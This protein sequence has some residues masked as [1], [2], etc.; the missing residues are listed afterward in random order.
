MRKLLSI[1]LNSLVLAQ[2]IVHNVNLYWNSNPDVS[3]YVYY[4]STIVVPPV[5]TKEWQTLFI[6]PGMQPS[7]GRTFKPIGNGV[8]QPVLTWGQSCA[9]DPTNARIDKEKK[10]WISAQYVNTDSSAQDPERKGCLG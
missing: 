9:P 6:W 7:N 8:L 10:W 2:E 3:P 4:E 5:P 1:F